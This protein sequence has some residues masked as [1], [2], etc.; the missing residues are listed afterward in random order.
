LTDLRKLTTDDLVRRMA[1]G[2]ISLMD[3]FGL[4][5]EKMLMR[6]PTGAIKLALDFAKFRAAV[7]DHRSNRTDALKYASI[8]LL[9]FV[10]PFEN[11][12]EW[13]ESRKPQPWPHKS[14]RDTYQAVVLGF[15]HPSLGEI[16]RLIAVVFEGLPYRK[17]LFPVNV[18][19]FESLT[20][21]REDLEKLGVFFAPVLTPHTLEKFH[22]ANPENDAI[23]SE[24]ARNL[25]I[26]YVKRA[27]NFIRDGQV[28]LVAPSARRQDTVFKTEKV[29]LGEEDI[30][31]RTISLLGAAA[32]RAHPER[33]CQFVPVA[34]VPP[35]SATRGLNLFRRYRLEFM[36]PFFL[37]KVRELNASKR[38]K[39]RS[40]VFE[41][42]FLERIGVGVVNCSREDLLFP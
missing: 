23:L 36:P 21:M 28:V 38:F 7:F 33:G 42:E 40:T 27:Q 15:N 12:T 22:A 16:L 31:P 8:K 10:A 30:E 6:W 26:N 9:K 34:V 2:E 1:T 37:D 17:Y 4:H 19:W 20:K 13:P 39:L 14:I 35:R 24:L 11:H 5:K 25:S 29:F 18:A 3:E 41:Y 32:C